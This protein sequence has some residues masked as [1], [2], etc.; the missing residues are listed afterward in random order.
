MCVYV[1]GV[2]VCAVHLTSS[3]AKFSKDVTQEVDPVDKHTSSFTMSVP[4]QSGLVVFRISR[5]TPERFKDGE[6]TMV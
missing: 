2:Y 3:I 4:P 5:G 1:G 6:E